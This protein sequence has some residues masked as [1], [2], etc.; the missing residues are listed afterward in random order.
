MLFAQLCGCSPCLEQP[1]TSSMPK[2][3]PLR[4]VLEA[5]GSGK[6]IIWHGAY[7]GK[8]PKPLQVWST[9]DLK[10]LV[11]LKPHNLVSDLVEKGTKRTSTGCIKKTYTGTKAL[12]AS[13]TYCLR[14]G[15]QVAALAK[16]WLSL[17]T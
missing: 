14:F 11:K 12:K 17:L 3:Q 8:A 2:L 10:A 7:S 13:Q 4:A 5:I 9:R 15:K 16:S 6:A 1:T